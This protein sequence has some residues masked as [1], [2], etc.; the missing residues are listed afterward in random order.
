MA[1]VVE[2]AEGRYVAGGASSGGAGRSGAI[3]ALAAAAVADAA[4]PDLPVGGGRARFDRFR[5]VDE[6]GHAVHRQ[7][8]KSTRLNSSHPS[9]SYAAVCQKKTRPGGVP[10]RIGAGTTSP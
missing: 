5:D 7:D 2:C 3:S 9:S 8:R 10:G 4:G 1:A 6:D